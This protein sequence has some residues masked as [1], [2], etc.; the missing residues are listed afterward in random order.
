MSDI[1]LLQQFAFLF[2]CFDF[3]LH[4]FEH[5]VAFWRQCWGNRYYFFVGGNFRFEMFVS[6][7][8]FSRSLYSLLS[9]LEVISFRL[10]RNMSPTYAAKHQYSTFQTGHQ[11]RHGILVYFIFF[12]LKGTW[13]TKHSTRQPVHAGQPAI[14]RRYLFFKTGNFAIS[15]FSYQDFAFHCADRIHFFFCSKNNHR[16]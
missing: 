9:P 8:S 2:Q 10:L 7:T 3:S 12:S 13:P 15:S 1:F 14:Q 4:L 16:Q 5:S 6:S 11:V